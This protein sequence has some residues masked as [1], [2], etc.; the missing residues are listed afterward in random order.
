MSLTHFPRAVKL[1]QQR[2][3]I[4][5][6]FLDSESLL[7]LRGGECGA[8]DRCSFASG[9]DGGLHLLVWAGVKLGRFAWAK[10]LAARG[11]KRMAFPALALH[12][13]ITY[14]RLF[15]SLR[16]WMKGVMQRG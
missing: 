3:Q 1:H 7:G 12:I 2:M 14:P 13:L 8:R 4:E 16:A 11:C 6:T 5:E 10:E 15:P 9:V